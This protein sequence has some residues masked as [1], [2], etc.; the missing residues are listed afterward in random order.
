M[1]KKVVDL[2]QRIKKEASRLNNEAKKMAHEC[3]DFE[4]ETKSR[5]EELK[6]LEAAKKAVAEATGA[7]A[8]RNLRLRAGVFLPL[9]PLRVG[10]VSGVDSNSAGAR[11]G[12]KSQANCTH[13]ACFASGIYDGR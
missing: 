9:A 3:E 7:A 13:A 2:R 11:P 1:A 6:A 4:S 10:L 5:A 8:K 12:T